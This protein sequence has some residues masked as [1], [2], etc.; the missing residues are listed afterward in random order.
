MKRITIFLLAAVLFLLPATGTALGDPGGFV[1]DTL[2]PSAMT[3]DGRIRVILHIHTPGH[4]PAFFGPGNGEMVDVAADLEMRAFV[5]GLASHLPG[6]AW[7]VSR[8]FQYLPLLA[9]EI[10]PDALPLLLEDP[11]VVAAF[12]DLPVPVPDSGMESCSAR[13][14][15]GVK[16]ADS[17]ESSGPTPSMA[18]IG[19]D[20]TAARGLTGEGRHVAVISTGIRSSHELFRGKTIVEACFSQLGHCP[21][22][23]KTMTGPGAAAHHPPNLRGYDVGTARAG[24]AAGHLDTGQV[25]VAPGADI[26]AV[27]VSSRFSAETC[28]GAPCVMAYLSDQIAALDYVLGL[29]DDHV[30]GA[31]DLAWS[32]GGH[33]VFCDDDP[34]KAAIAQLR[35]ANIPTVVG[36]GVNGFCGLLPAPGC[37]SSAITVTDSTIVDQPRPHANWHQTMVNLFAPG[38]NIPVASGDSDRMG[39][40]RRSGMGA[41]HVVG[42]MTLARQFNEN[43]TVSMNLATLTDGGPSIRASCPD[44]KAR[45]RLYVNTFSGE[46][47]V[48]LEPEKVVEAGARWRRS[49][50]EPWLNS[51]DVESGVPAGAHTVE[52]LEVEQWTTPDPVDVFI[53][54]KRSELTAAYVAIPPQIAVSAAAG[55]GGSVTPAAQTVAQGTAATIT[56]IAEPGFLRDKA[57]GTC[58]PGLFSGMT[59]ATGPVTEPCTLSFSFAPLQP[60][61]TEIGLANTATTEAKSTLRFLDPSGAELGSCET[62]LSGYASRRIISGQDDCLPTP[63]ALSPASSTGMPGYA[64]LESESENLVGYVRFSRP[65]QYRAALPLR[66]GNTTAVVYLPQIASNSVWS[67]GINLTN[68]SEAQISTTLTFNTNAMTSLLLTPGRQLESTIREIFNNQPSPDLTSAIFSDAPALATAMFGGDGRP[69]L[70]ALDLSGDTATRMIIPHV[71]DPAQ[72]VTGMAVLNTAD[73]TAQLSLLCTDAGGNLLKTVVL[74][75]LD[76]GQRLAGDPDSL[77]CPVGTAWFA[78]ESTVPLSGLALFGDVNDSRLAGISLANLGARNGFFPGLD[79]EGW[80]T[81]ALV[82]TESDQALLTLT[83]HAATGETLS[84]VQ[85]SIPALGKIS[86]EPKDF[87]PDDVGTASLL[88]YVS[89]RALAGCLI[90]GSSDETMLDALPALRGEGP[91]QFLPIIK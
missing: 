48:T 60:W 41:P 2:P 44:G 69:I 57:D 19:A 15:F 78:V 83:A 53:S 27:N 47:Q 45:R 38:V 16:P 11:W 14:P 5:A 32:A 67:T 3:A 18:L 79:P 91:I 40:T 84:Q 54:G 12:P 1:L 49:G 80:S 50:T 46:L 33:N 31:V 87:F 73:Q 82:N 55:E 22:G 36:S 43:A 21:N 7:S 4:P 61:I 6:E 76:Q 17:R 37:V 65:G 29:K 70:A 66:P 9:L 85:L 25:G 35:A 68:A 24:V 59:Y 63:T 51:G 8:R 71:A 62:T 90:S 72:W 75:D 89:N 77:G 26:I 28:G 52:F 74:P 39:T 81:L 34:R 13:K 56:L 10:A 86:G 23:E 58:P 88:R 20:K 30:I 64:R 42:A